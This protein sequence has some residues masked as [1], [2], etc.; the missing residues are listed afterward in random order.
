MAYTAILVDCDLSEAV[1]NPRQWPRGWRSASAANLV[2]L[3]TRPPFEL[4][5]F[6]D[7]SFT[8][9]RFFTAYEESEKLDQAC[10]FTAFNTAIKGKDLSSK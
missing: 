3:H 9:D 5:A 7:G 1:A 10:A 6:F 2:G 4:P 8:M